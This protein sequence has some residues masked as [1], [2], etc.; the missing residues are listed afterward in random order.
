MIDHERTVSRSYDITDS[1]VDV[2]PDHPVNVLGDSVHETTREVVNRLLP[3]TNSN[4]SERSIED[5]LLDMEI[6]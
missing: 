5:R 4:P 2:I 1:N 6:I 3:E